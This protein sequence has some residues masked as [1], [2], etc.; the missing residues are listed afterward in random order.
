MLAIEFE[1][2]VRDGVVKIPAE[3]QNQ[4]SEDVKV[5]ILMKDA[6]HNSRKG[7][8]TLTSDPIKVRKI[9]LPPR[10]ELHER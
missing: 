7:L 1:T 3:Y 8:S 9:I 2:K 6:S 10:E 5:I 4:I